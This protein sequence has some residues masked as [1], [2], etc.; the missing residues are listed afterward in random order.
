MAMLIA[1]GCNSDARG[2]YPMLERRFERI[3]DDYFPTG[4]FVKLKFRDFSQTTME[5]SLAGSAPRWRE[6]D[7]FRNLLASAWPRGGKPVRLLGAG[8]RLRP[9]YG[10]A[11]EQLLLFEGSDHSS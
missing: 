4:R 11:G 7:G 8:L 3:D 9:R 1:W 2:W 10:E 5:E 6:R